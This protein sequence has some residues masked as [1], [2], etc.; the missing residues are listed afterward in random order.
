MHGVKKT[1][2]EKYQMSF[3]NGLGEMG[4]GEMERHPNFLEQS[5]A[6]VSSI[7]RKSLIL[8]WKRRADCSADIL[9]IRR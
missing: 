2:V 4:L 9:A 1:W 6:P 5:Y 3:C 7:D 8:H